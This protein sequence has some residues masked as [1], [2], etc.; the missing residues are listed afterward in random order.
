MYYSLICFLAFLLLIITNYDVLRR[1]NA[2]DAP[3]HRFYRRFLLVII[4]FYLIDMTWGALND[5]PYSPLLFWVT[6][7][8]FLA[9]ALAI[10]FWSQ[11]VIAYLERENA[12]QAFLMYT[13]KGFFA[14]VAVIAAINIVRPVLF[15]FD[16]AG[17]YHTAP[18][19]HVVLAVQILLLLMTA[20]YALRV[21][22]NA[23][24]PERHRHLT[25]GLSGLFMTVFITIQLFYPLLPLYAIAYMLGSS[26]LR[27]FVI[28]Y[29]KEEYR[30]S[31]ETALASEKKAMQELNAAW[32]L[33][34]TDPLTGA[35]SKLAYGEKEDQIDQA[36]S[37]GTAKTGAVAVFDLN[38]LKTINDTAG[39]DAGNKYIV[40][41][42]RLICG[43]FAHSPVYRV[44]GDEFCVI[45][46]GQDYENRDRLMAQ[47]NRQVEENLE[48]GGVVI[49]G[50]L[51]VY[52][53]AGQNHSFRR[54]F[55]RADYQMYK[56]KREL[57]LLAGEANGPD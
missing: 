12:F 36:M 27:T 50:G 21:S 5:L 14:A 2:S 7:L 42:F 51:A 53:P 29:E 25:I 34:Y 32:R 16:A 6:E 39:H 15:R 37:D 22:A 8:Y 17:V 3:A 10:L 30:R 24:D 57:K 26:L 47:F 18:M 56:R 11:Y 19:R 33:A 48:T 46:E 55:E 28:E 1:P 38:G 9:M 52:D 43:I 49:A 20:V 54:V 4:A 23:E 40:S 41:A 35:K 31:L 44:G 13:G 45:L